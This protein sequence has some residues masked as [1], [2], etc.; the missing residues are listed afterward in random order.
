MSGKTQSGRIAAA[1]KKSAS[2]KRAA[3]VVY[4]TAGDPDFSRSLEIAKA[5]AEAGADILEL[6][7]PFSDPLADGEANQ[8]ASNRALASGM[9]S[10][11]IPD[12]AA[13]IKKAHPELPVVLF[14]YMNPV[15]YAGDFKKFC[16]RAAESGVDAILPL[17]LPPEE[18]GAYKDAIEGAGLG[19]VSL[20]APNTAPERVKSLCGYAS[21]FVYYVSREGVT[22]ER[23]DFASDAGDRMKVIKGLSSLP[24]V[25]GFG[26]STPEHVK[27]AASTGADGV[28][29]GSAIVR[30]VE[31][32]SKG[33]CSV[34]DIAAFIKSLR[35]ACAR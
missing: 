23:K 16:A 22:G 26:I 34:A 15:A 30:K 2:E 17:D 24:V 27:A 4:I 35:A 9:T 25:I 3:L 29:V 19:V 14:T 32:L 11:K 13:E 18:Y 8:L 12:L 5:A 1:F 10:A 7:A 6:G 31:A 20:V 21:S 33:Q 28:V